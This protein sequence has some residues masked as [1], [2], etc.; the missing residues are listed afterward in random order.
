MHI[1]LDFDR[2]AARSAQKASSDH[3]CTC[4]INRALSAASCAA[5]EF[6]FAYRVRGPLNVSSAAKLLLKEVKTSRPQGGSKATH[7]CSDLPGPFSQWYRHPDG[8]KR[9][10]PKR[11][12]S[13][14][15][16]VVPGG[17]VFISEL[18]T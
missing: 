14:S 2:A 10:S 15:I 12:S 5:N 11:S 16:G 13:S 1:L 3:A 18:P 4:S 17:S 9:K 6:E 7:T 8:R